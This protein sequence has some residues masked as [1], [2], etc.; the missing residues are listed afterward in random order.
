MYINLKKRVDNVK[1]DKLI[2][3]KVNKIEND[4]IEYLCN[5]LDMNRSQLF[6]Y[7]VEKAWYLEKESDKD[8]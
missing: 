2:T 8:E 4:R 7:L 1:K 6:L 3:M 5:K